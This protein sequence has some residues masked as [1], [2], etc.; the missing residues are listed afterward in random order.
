MITVTL[1]VI[2]QGEEGGER[3]KVGREGR[4]VVGHVSHSVKEHEHGSERE[5]CEF[6]KARYESF[7]R[8]CRLTR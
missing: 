3:A 1:N 7:A 2:A 5:R 6:I 8:P 4:R